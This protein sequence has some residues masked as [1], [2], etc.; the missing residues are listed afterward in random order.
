M[1]MKARLTVAWSEFGLGMSI[2]WGSRIAFGLGPIL[3]GIY[4]GPEMWRYLCPACGETHRHE[5]KR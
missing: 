1:K 4:W 2:T 5:G 3:L